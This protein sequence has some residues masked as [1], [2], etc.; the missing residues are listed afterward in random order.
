M[1]FRERGRETEF[2]FLK[3]VIVYDP[4][5]SSTP[6]EMDHE[7]RGGTIDSQQSVSSS[8]KSVTII[9]VSQCVL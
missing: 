9:K 5:S 8:S 2:F 6:L 3:N 4:R 7:E 1:C